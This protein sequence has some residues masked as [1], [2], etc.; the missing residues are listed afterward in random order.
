MNCCSGPMLL[1]PLLIANHAYTLTKTLI[2][3]HILETVGTPWSELKMWVRHD[4]WL[5]GHRDLLVLIKLSCRTVLFKRSAVR[6]V[7][8]R[9]FTISLTLTL[10]IGNFSIKLSVTI[11]IK[12]VFVFTGSPEILFQD[13]RGLSKD[14]YPTKLPNYSSNGTWAFGGLNL[15]FL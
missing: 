14:V 2:C 9:G 3:H 12:C 6:S 13:I 11:E 7:R 8:P 5:D 10:V 1:G 4:T 15:P